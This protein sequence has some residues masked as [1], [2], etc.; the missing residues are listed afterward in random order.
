M[1]SVGRASD[2]LTR[3]VGV[4]GRFEEG[5]HGDHAQLEGDRDVVL[6]AP[7]LARIGFPCFREVS[8]PRLGNHAE[9]AQLVAD[10]PARF[11][12]AHRNGE[13]AVVVGDAPDPQR[14]AHQQCHRL[15][16]LVRGE[17]AEPLVLAFGKR[18][19]VFVA[20]LGDGVQEV[21]GLECEIGLE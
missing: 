14:F 9:V 11:G 20:A 4:L 10:A 16:A 5:A 19:P 3:K 21:L 8:F 17:P 15:L 13:E 7:D 6:Q 1:Y 12:G 2:A 18:N